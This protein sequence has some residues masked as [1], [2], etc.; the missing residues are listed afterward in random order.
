MNTNKES[1]WYQAANSG[2]ILGLILVIISVIIYVFDLVTMS[3]FAGFYI[4]V[5]NLILYF[6]IIFV[7]SKNYRNK[8]LGGY[9]TYGNSLKFG[10]LIGVFASLI[11]ALYQIIF[12]TIIDPDYQ[13]IT[14]EKIA[15]M[16]EEY[17]LSAGLSEEMVEQQMAAFDA[18]EIPTPINAALMSI[19]GTI[20]FTFIVSLLTSIF[21]KKKNNN[22]FADAMTEVNDSTEKTE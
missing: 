13:K 5:I 8:I 11:S 21:V 17:M 9:I 10:I 12:N 6:I 1:I 14:M 18:R 15:A 4:G 22:A 19:P 7:L 16:T 20:I 2:L 3:L